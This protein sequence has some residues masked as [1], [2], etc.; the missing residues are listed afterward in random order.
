MGMDYDG[1]V[2]IYSKSRDET[3]LGISNYE[4]IKDMLKDIPNIEENN[5]T[6][7]ACGYIDV[8]MIHKDNITE[9]IQNK[10]MDIFDR[11]DGYPVIN[12]EDYSQKEL[13][14]TLEN[15]DSAASGYT[16][17]DLPDT[18]LNDVYNWFWN[19]DQSAIE[20]SDDSGG[21]PDKDQII[22]ALK[23]LNF[24]DISLEE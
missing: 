1:Y 20:N 13:D 3:L 21:Y 24:F 4:N 10:I 6:H 15:I 9:D 7:W 19:N 2:C 17:T 8:I 5:F 23:A 16:K 22:K 18:W 11:L 12:E 14:S